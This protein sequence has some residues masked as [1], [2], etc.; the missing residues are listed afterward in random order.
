MS[1]T[2]RRED[3]RFIPFRLCISELGRMAFLGSSLVDPLFE[4]VVALLHRNYCWFKS[5]PP[6]TDV[7]NFFS[8]HQHPPVH[9][10][11]FQKVKPATQ[12]L[13]MPITLLLSLDSL[14]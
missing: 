10:F 14:P 3:N 5:T 12:L 11:V 9:T 4:K 7:S 13:G 8:E 1:Q 2:F 6:I